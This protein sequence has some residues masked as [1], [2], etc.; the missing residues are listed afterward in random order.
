MH[1]SVII[2]HVIFSLFYLNCNEQ[3]IAIIRNGTAKSKKIK[4]IAAP[5]VLS[6]I[7]ILLRVTQAAGGVKD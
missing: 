1:N 4:P 7:W 3:T 6:L 5:S 2:F